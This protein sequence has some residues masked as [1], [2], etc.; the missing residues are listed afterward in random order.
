M[1]LAN[2]F[3]AYSLRPRSQ[4]LPGIGRL[5]A[6]PPHLPQANWRRSLRLRFRRQSL[7]T[8]KC[9]QIIRQ[10][11]PIKGD[12]G[13]SSNLSQSV[14]RSAYIV[15]LTTKGTITSLSSEIKKKV[16]RCRHLTFLREQ[17]NPDSKYGANQSE[18]GV[19]IRSSEH[20]F[21]DFVQQTAL[22]RIVTN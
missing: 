18:L 12:L 1:L 8:R 9:E 19:E 13:G 5:E 22:R 14:S 4:A 2:Y 17:S 3:A 20:A 16:G 11:H 7:G 21:K 6:L 10:Q 15:D